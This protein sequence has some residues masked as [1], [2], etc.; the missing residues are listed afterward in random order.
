MKYDI[1]DISSSNIAMYSRE[2]VVTRDKF[3]CFPESADDKTKKKIKKH[4]LSQKY[5]YNQAKD[6][7][8]EIFGKNTPPEVMIRFLKECHLLRTETEEKES[9]EYVYENIKK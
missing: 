1:K 8:K 3:T 5:L 6:E 2:Y 4:I 7:Y 9:K